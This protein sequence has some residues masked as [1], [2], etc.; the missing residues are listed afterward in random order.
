M[1]NEEFKGALHTLSRAMMAQANR[2][3]GATVNDLDITMSSRLKEFVKTNP[4]NFLVIK[5]R[6]DPKHFW[7]RCIR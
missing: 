5:V 2:Y 3:V 7:V 6:V 4:P 1:K